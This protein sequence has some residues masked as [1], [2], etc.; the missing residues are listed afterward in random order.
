MVL[1][2]ISD[3]ALAQNYKSIFTAMKPGSTIGLSHGFLLSHLQ[4]VGEEFPKDMN[5]IAVCPKGMGPSVRRLYEQGREVNG[6]GINSSFAVHQDINGKATDYALAWAIGLGSPF[7]FQTTLSLS[8][9]QTYSGEE[10][11][12]LVRPRIAESLYAIHGQGVQKDEAYINTS[13]SITGPISKTISRSGL[14]AVY[15]ELSIV[16]KASF[17]KAYWHRI[18]LLGDFG[19]DL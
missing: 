4:S 19:G 5:V 6:A 17:R 1:L 14:M 2:L 16:R 9:D 12:F 15:E 3:A 11:S 13:E 10:V 7:T 18:I 8:I